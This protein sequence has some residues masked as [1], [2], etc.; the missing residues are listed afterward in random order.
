MDADFERERRQN[1]AGLARNTELQTTSRAFMVQSAAARYSYNFDWLGVP[2]IQYPQDLIM[3]QELIWRIRPEVIVETG[4]ARGGSVVF[5]ASM[6]TL[7]DGNGFVVGI[8]I[9]IRA[10]NRTAIEAHPMTRRIRLVEGSSVSE[11]VVSRV[12]ELVGDR[13]PV[14]V[15]LDSN[16]T[17]EHVLQELEMYSPLVGRGS[18]LVVFDTIVDAM[19]T[20]SYP[21][22]PWGPGNNP[23]TA[24]REFL[25]HND[26]F[27]VD[28]TIDAKLQISVA[29]GGYLKCIRDG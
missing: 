12:K 6:L 20:D 19:P 16:H 15:V 27:Q 8:D 23:M 4:V 24:V 13:S 25:R 2:I 3:M 17:H 21:D 1:L 7:L 5:Y 11:G 14:L 9:D 26:R 18:Y 10:H 29:P 22:R 28:Q